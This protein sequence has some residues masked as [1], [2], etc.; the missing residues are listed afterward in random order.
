MKRPNLLLV[1]PWIHDFAAYDLWSVPMG[2]LVL[3]G[4]LKKMGYELSFL[5]CTDP[6]HPDLPERKSTRFETGNFGKTS[7]PKPP[8]IKNVKR[9]FSRYGVP[10]EIVRKELSAL[11]KPDVIL[12]TSIMTYWYS[13]VFETIDMIKEAF[14]ETPILLGGIYATLMPAHAGKSGVHVIPG[15]GE[16][17]LPE[18]L[19]QLTGFSGHKTFQRKMQFSP[20]LSLLRKVNFLPLLTSRGCPFKCVYCASSALES[21]YVRRDPEDVIVE[22]ERAVDLYEMKDV[23]LYDDAFLVQ[24]EQYAK[25]ILRESVSRVPGLR[26]HSPNGLHAAFIDDEMATLMKEAGFETIRIGLESSD[27]DFQKSTGDKTNSRQFLNAV[28]SLK[29]A[30]FRRKQI[31]VYLL[32]GL[33]GQ[34]AL[35]IEKDVEFVLK[36]GAYPRPA[37]YSPIPGSPLWK[38]VAA[39][40]GLPLS[41]EPLLQNNTLMSVA[42]PDV[43]KAFIEKIRKGIAQWVN[44]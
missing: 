18:M 15:H 3:A 29:A 23:A 28:K 34:T 38:K 33:P 11:P 4:L 2:L 5:D 25:K 31:G 37:E 35:M 17:A 21:Q 1:N 13:G 32:V 20:E 27:N 12:V 19:A 40:S 39:E 8:V 41:D 36:A 43:N 22:I 6:H 24:P 7:I 26:W 42:E 10:P 9:K 30:G 44:D 16:A 14:P